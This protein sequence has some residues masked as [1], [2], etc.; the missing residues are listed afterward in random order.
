MKRINLTESRLHKIIKE[1]IRKTLNESE[2]DLWI[3]GMDNDL[4]SLSQLIRQ[5]K[6]ELEGNYDNGNLEEKMNSAF[7]MAD[8][9]CNFIKEISNKWLHSNDNLR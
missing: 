6:G 8:K 4:N 9:A 3:E 7:K 1:S 2:H 5:I